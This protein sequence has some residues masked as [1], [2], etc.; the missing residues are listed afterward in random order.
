MKKVLSAL[1]AI[2]V[3]LT[4]LAACNTEEPVVDPD[5]GQVNEEVQGNEE[6]SDMLTLVKD[7]VSDYVIIVPHGQTDT[8]TV[9]VKAI[10]VTFAQAVAPTEAVYNKTKATLEIVGGGF[11]A[12]Y[13]NGAEEVIEF[14]DERVTLSFDRNTTEETVEITAKF[15]DY[16][17]KFTAT[18]VV[19]IVEEP[20]TD[21]NTSIFGCSASISAA[22]SLTVLLGGLAVA[23]VGKRK[24]EE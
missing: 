17:C 24:D 16:S 12:Y 13:N 20:A 21:N 1:L 11:T 14:L 8:F 22:M 2:S 23:F 9:E 5:D 10:V 6:V 3:I 18:V 19:E 4:M 15:G 7:G